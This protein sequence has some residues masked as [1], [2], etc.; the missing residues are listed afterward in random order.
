MLLL[1]VVLMV[2]VLCGSTALALSPMGPPTA[3]LKKG[4]YSAAFEYGYSETDI[5]VSGYGLSAAVENV[6]S[7]MF[8]AKGGYGI[9]DNWEAFLRLGT[10]NAEV[11]IFDGDY[12]FAIG[13]GTKVT[14]FE[15]SPDLNWG[16]LFQIG[17]M[18]SK[19]TWTFDVYSG[20]AEIDIYEIQI[21]LGPTYQLKENVSLYGGP[22]LH[23]IGG[24]FDITSGGVT[25]SF[26]L[27]QESE[28]GGYLG[29]Q[30]DLNENCSLYVEGQ[31]TGDAEAL[32]VGIVYR[33]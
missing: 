30:V 23:F 6:E 8:F 18:Q 25:Y 33:F 27:E 26:D 7:N 4:Q 2:V 14:F 16:G 13:F 12:G 28:F 19:D 11:E 29:T 31:L 24:D 21:A 9:N 5:Q 10:A 20:D 3:G 17:W 22:F 32:C 15:Q 1:G